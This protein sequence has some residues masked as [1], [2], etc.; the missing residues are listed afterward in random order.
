MENSQYIKLINLPDRIRNFNNSRRQTFNSSE[1][2][3]IETISKRLDKFGKTVKGKR[4]AAKDL[5]MSLATL[6]RK[7]K[8]HN[9][10]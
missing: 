2:N 9:I 8:K 6:Y 7:I 4:L 1:K 5:S 3:E 10:S